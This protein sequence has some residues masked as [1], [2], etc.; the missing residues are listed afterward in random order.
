MPICKKCSK[1]IPCTVEIDG[2]RRHLAHRKYCLECNPFG[3]RLYTGIRPD[4]EKWVAG[5]VGQGRRQTEL[6]SICKK[7]GR[8]FVLRRMIRNL[9]CSTCRNRARRKM[10]KQRAVDFL[11]GKC[12]RCGYCKTIKG[13]DF[14]HLDPTKKEF[15]LSWAMNRSWAMVEKEL[16]KCILLCKNCHAEEH[17]EDL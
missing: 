5:G 15:N 2:R 6:N 11:G 4:A 13:M 8:A 12:C 3:K 14:H 9:E 17:D 16:G 1:R 7:C 10:I